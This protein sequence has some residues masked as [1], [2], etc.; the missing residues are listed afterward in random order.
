MISAT[1]QPIDE[2]YQQ[3]YNTGFEDAVHKLEK[4]VKKLGKKYLKEFLEDLKDM[5]NGKYSGA[6][7]TITNHKCNCDFCNI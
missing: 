2:G 4:K 6:S 7:F 3:G 1:P 5:D